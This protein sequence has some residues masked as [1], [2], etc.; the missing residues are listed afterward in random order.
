MDP[1]SETELLVH[2]DEWT[3]RLF[4]ELAFAVRVMTEDTHPEL[5]RAWRAIIEA[6]E[7]ARGRALAVLQ[8]VS[9]IDYDQALGRIKQGLGSKNQEDAVLL[10]RD[11]GEGFRRNYRRAESIARGGE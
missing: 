10:A 5:A 9:A 8:D 6:P 4:Q 1:Y 3:G 11:L 7:P 2:H